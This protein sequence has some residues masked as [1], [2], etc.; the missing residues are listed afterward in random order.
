MLNHPTLDKL[1]QLRLRGMA[2]AFKEQME[3]PE[4]EGLSFTDRLALL[5]D[6][7]VTERENWHLKIRLRNAKLKQN[8]C[9]EDIDSRSPRGCDK[10]LMMRLAGCDWIR[11]QDNV[12]IAGSSRSRPIASSAP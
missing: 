9:V 4:V 2:K 3:Q 6:R 1:H 5:V 8:A 12:L 11:H 7:E 10:A